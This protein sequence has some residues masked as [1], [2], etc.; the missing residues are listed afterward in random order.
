MGCAKIEGW[1]PKTAVARRLFTAEPRTHSIT[2]LA[3]LSDAIHFEPEL[4]GRDSHFWL[5]DAF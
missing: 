2:M 5:S 4:L 3:P 1:L